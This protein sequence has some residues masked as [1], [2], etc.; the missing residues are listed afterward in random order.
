MILMS[1]LEAIGSLSLLIDT[2][3]GGELPSFSANLGLLPIISSLYSVSMASSSICWRWSSVSRAN[4]KIKVDPVCHVETKSM[5][6]PLL[7]TIFLETCSPMAMSSPFYCSMKISGWS[8]YLIP[9][10]SSLTVITS[11]DSTLSKLMYT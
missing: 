1:K 9:C 4:V 11:L 6:P 2:I 7:S 3:P 8:S 5:D 10:P